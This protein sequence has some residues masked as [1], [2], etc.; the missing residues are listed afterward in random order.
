M[1]SNGKDSL[2]RWGKVKSRT[3]YMYA[4]RESYSPIVP[5]K[6]ANEGPLTARGARPPTGGV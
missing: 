4:V 6:Q 1:A 2:D 3:P 5:L